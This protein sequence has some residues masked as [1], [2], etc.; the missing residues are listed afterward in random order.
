V[1]TRQE[2]ERVERRL[3]QLWTRRARRRTLVTAGV[4]VTGWLLLG[5]SPAEAA[6]TV[7]SVPAGTPMAAVGATGPAGPSGVGIV[8][9]TAGRGADEGRVPG[10]TPTWSE[11]LDKASTGRADGG[12]VDG[13]VYDT[14]WVV[15]AHVAQSGQAT[16]VVR[17]RVTP[18]LGGVVGAAEPVVE[19]VG[20]VIP[21]TPGEPGVPSRMMDRE[22]P[23]SSVEAPRARTEARTEAR[24]D[25]GAATA[26][27][28]RPSSGSWPG[29]LSGGRTFAGPGIGAD[30]G[31]VLPHPVPVPGQSQDVPDVTTSTASGHGSVD[32][33]QNAS[34]D[35]SPLVV[36]P[37]LLT[38]LPA[39]SRPTGHRERAIRP[40]VSPD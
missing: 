30:A 26:D 6:P 37:R 8:E 28:A 19:P 12:R 11:T 20:E 16:E 23:G 32:R 31:P 2:S 24:T 33:G 29:V 1:T 18:T 17:P 27:S 34:G 7:P 35:T 22:T 9:Q 15:K 14:V 40:S 25:T 5:G 21:A 38:S 36:S 13:V 3:P 10:L 4:V 39:T